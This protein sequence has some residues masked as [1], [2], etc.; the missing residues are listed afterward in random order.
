MDT[1]L[2]A[3]LAV[4]CNV[5]AQVAMKFSGAADAGRWLWGLSAWTLAA[6]ALYGASFFLTLQVFARSP[7]SLAS[8]I[9]AGCTVVLV[10]LA[11]V[12]LF[13]EPWGWT[14]IAGTALVALG[15]L[16]LLA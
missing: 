4:A 9:M 5:S 1:Q 14:K 13:G 15:I 16:L 12:L 3:L 10:A 11:G 6:L 7:L 8:P 2:I